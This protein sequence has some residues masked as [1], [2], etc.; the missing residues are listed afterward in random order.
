M[1]TAKSNLASSAESVFDIGERLTGLLKQ[2]KQEAIDGG[3]PGDVR[4]R[5]ADT[6]E[7]L[8]S[9][10]VHRWNAILGHCSISTTV[11]LNSSSVPTKRRKSAKSRQNSFRRSTITWKRS[12]QKWI[13]LRVTGA[14]KSRLPRSAQKK[15]SGCQ[16][17]GELLNGE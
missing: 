8:R 12:K 4:A 1:A 11:S 7:A 3:L 5:L 14:G 15:Q 17:G 2:A 6:V 10:V 16:R 9:R 13:G